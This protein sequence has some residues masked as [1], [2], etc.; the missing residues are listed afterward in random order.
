[1]T[2]EVNC[3]EFHA[4]LDALDALTFKDSINATSSYASPSAS[5][6][7]GTRDNKIEHGKDCARASSCGHRRTNTNAQN[8]CGHIKNHNN[9]QQDVLN[10]MESFAYNS[11]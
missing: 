8:P 9:P 11:K 2:R 6:L 7:S 10:W 1:M 3:V 4:K 5:E